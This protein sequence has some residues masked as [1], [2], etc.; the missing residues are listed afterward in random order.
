M[1]YQAVLTTIGAAKIAAAIATDTQISI[2][3]IKIGDGGGAETNPAPEDTDL[4]NVVF[5]D[6]P[7][8]IRVDPFNGSRIVA[9][10]LVPAAEGGWTAREIGIYDGDGDLIALSRMP[11][12][13][14]PL[15]SEGATADFVCRMFLVISDTSAITLTIDTGVT[16]ATQDWVNNQ[17]SLLIPGGTTDQVL[18]KNSNTDGDYSWKDASGLTS[19]V[20]II[21]EVQTL[22]G[23]QT[24]VNL[25]T[26]TT[27]DLAIYIN[28]VRL[29]PSQWTATSAT[30]VTLAVGATGGDLFHAVQNDPAGTADFLK[31]GNNLSD[32]PNKTQA[33]AN[34]ELLTISTY[35]AALWTEMQKLTY[36]I[37]EIITTRRAGNPSTWLGFGTWERYGAGRVLVG[38]DEADAS[39]NTLDKTGGSK[40]HTLTVAELPPHSHVVDLR[41]SGGDGR[42][43]GFAEEAGNLNYPRTQNTQNTG[44]GQ[45]HNNLQPY[46]TVFMWKRTA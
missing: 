24:V 11:E 10:I 19:I 46:I 30:T 42:D 26:C 6:V 7:N 15:P 44:S 18:A 38:Y 13:Y 22:T 32:V 33:R 27:D 43:T 29:R 1:S 23:G 28:G 25:T 8:A 17:L 4:V 39:F 3:E 40:N 31:A 20:E 21:E 45:A 12:I 5:S 9:E 36:P 2:D 37:G 14:K 34:L 35:L 16:V 41:N